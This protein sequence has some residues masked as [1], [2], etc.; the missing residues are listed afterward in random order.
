MDVETRL[1]QNLSD[2]SQFVKAGTSTVS[3]EE[4]EDLQRTHRQ[5]HF[6]YRVSRAINTTLEQDGLFRGR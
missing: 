2:L 3:S 4:L 5:M 6:I 1:T